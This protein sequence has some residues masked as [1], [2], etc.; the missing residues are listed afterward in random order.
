MI[1]IGLVTT[2]IFIVELF[3]LF[4]L[5]RGISTSV[6]SILYKL[7]KS[8][9]FTVSGLAVLFLPG[10]VVHELSHILVAG[11]LMVPVGEMEFMPQIHGNEVK[12]GSAQIGLTDPFRRAIIGMAP[13]LVGTAIIL[14][15]LWLFSSFDNIYLKI[16]TL[17]MVFEIGN[18]MFSSKKDS[19]G[20]YALLLALGLVAILVWGVLFFLHIQIPYALIASQ[21]FNESYNNFLRMGIA[22]L[23]V[24]IGIDLVIYLLAKMIV[25]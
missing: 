10:T 25:R 1:T 19:E 7:S 12:L 16:I 15:V 5:S 18:T 4:L 14:S 22:F 9:S 2:F 3:F 23:G 24:P 6:S 11:V 13:L 8:Q 17:F 20:L 21:I